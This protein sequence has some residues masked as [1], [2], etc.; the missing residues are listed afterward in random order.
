MKRQLIWLRDTWLA[1]IFVGFMV[2][3]GT[4]IGIRD[5]KPHASEADEAA[6]ADA[7]AHYSVR[8]STCEDHVASKDACESALAEE[9]ERVHERHT[10][11]CTPEHHRII[12]YPPLG[13]LMP[14]RPTWVRRGSAGRHQRRGSAHQGYRRWRAGV[15]PRRS[16][17]PNV[18]DHRSPQGAM[19]P[20][21]HRARD[22]A[23][24]QG[25]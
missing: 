25:E 12:E 20:P 19:P 18:M 24:L 21:A 4:Y 3:G 13:W 14:G 17:P 5:A 9:H 10:G 7:L 2:R 23:C 6:F 15:G 16:G 1:V 8:L 11:S 22:R